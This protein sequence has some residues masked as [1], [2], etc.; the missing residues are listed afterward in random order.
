MNNNLSALPEFASSA[1]LL[2]VRQTMELLNMKSRTTLARYVKRGWLK[3]IKMGSH[4]SSPAKFR[5]DEII[6]S[7]DNMR[8]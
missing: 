6:W 7:L 1:R 8:K 4:R 5:Y 2:N 3:P